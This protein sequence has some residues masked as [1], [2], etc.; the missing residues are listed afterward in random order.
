VHMVE[1]TGCYEPRKDMHEK[2]ME[3]YKRYE[4]V[5]DAVRPLM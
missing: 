2:Y 5:Y 1:E 4:H 3:I